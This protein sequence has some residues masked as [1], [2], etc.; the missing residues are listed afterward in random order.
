MCFSSREND[1]ERFVSATE[2][3]WSSSTLLSSTTSSRL[4]FVLFAFRSF[5][6]PSRNRFPRISG[7]ILTNLTNLTVVR[8]NSLTVRGLIQSISARCDAHIERF[9]INPKLSLLKSYSRAQRIWHPPLPSS[10][11]LCGFKFFSSLPSRHIL[12]HS[13]NFSNVTI[14]ENPWSFS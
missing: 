5:A 3:N 12:R 9:T 11:L 7:I 4:S 1:F 14:H 8:T 6:L 2:V 13:K 10:T